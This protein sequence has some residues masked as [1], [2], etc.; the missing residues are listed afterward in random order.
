MTRLMDNLSGYECPTSYGLSQLTVDPSEKAIFISVPEDFSQENYHAFSLLPSQ[1]YKADLPS[2]L[3]D[4][5]DWMLKHEF[6]HYLWDLKAKPCRAES[7]DACALEDEAQSDKMT[8]KQST[9]AQKQ[10]IMDTRAIGA[11][12]GSHP[13]HNTAPFISGVAGKKY[14]K[15]IAGSREAIDTVYG[16]IRHNLFDAESKPVITEKTPQVLASVL[17]SCAADRKDQPDRI[18]GC[19]I[20]REPRVVPALAARIDPRDLS[21]AAQI[22]LID[23]FRALG[24]EAKIEFYENEVTDYV[25]RRAGFEPAL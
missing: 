12:H 16:M 17:E 14:D 9:P 1:Y 5:I 19:V 21:S 11:M 10:R 4:S 2:L 24:R 25:R 7:T 13:D 18:P 6:N 3:P 22:Y 8:V 15:F 23:Y 20:A